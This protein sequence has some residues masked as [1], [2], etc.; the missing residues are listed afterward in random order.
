MPKNH[1]YVMKPRSELQ[2]MYQEIVGKNLVESIESDDDNEV[3]YEHLIR[4]S[5]G[6]RTMPVVNVITN[7]D[8]KITTASIEMT[9]SGVCVSGVGS[10]HCH[11]DDR[12]IRE[13]GDMIAISRAAHAFSNGLNKLAIKLSTL[14]GNTLNMSDIHE[15]S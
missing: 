9:V 15:E 4:S 1:T 14:R 12:Y 7:P 3:V 10:S 8:A 5:F 2:E 13:V 11:P 6:D